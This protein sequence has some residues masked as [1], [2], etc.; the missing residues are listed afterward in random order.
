M[1]ATDRLDR[2]THGSIRTTSR[3]RLDRAT[4]GSIR[5]TS[6]RYQ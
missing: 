4:H 6:R 2:A 5:T 3:D 1:T